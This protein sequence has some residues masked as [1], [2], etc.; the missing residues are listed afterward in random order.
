MLLALLKPRRTSP[1]GLNTLFDLLERQRRAKDSLS[2]PLRRIPGGLGQVRKD[3]TLR[4]LLHRLRK[5]HPVGSELPVVSVYTLIMS[6]ATIFKATY[7][8]VPVY[9]MPC[10]SVPVMR[11]RVDNWVNATQILKV[12]GFDKP[13]RTRV[14]EREVQKAIH[15]KIQGGYGKY[16]GTWIP[17][18]RGVALAQQ[19]G[20]IALLQPIFDFQPTGDSPPLAPKHLTAP[21]SRPKRK[22]DTPLDG[23]IPRP[24]QKRTTHGDPA[25]S[26]SDIPIM[27][28][29][30]RAGRM[31][32]S[33]DHSLSP[34]PSDHSST[35][36]TPSPLDGHYTDYD[37]HGNAVSAER[38]RPGYTD[39]NGNHQ[40][41]QSAGGPVRYARLILDYFVSESSH[42]PSFLLAPP[43]DFDPNVVIDDDGHTALH[44]A[45]AMGRIRIVKLLLTAGADIFRANAMGQ[46]ALMRSVMFTNN[47][48][49]RKFPELFELLHRSTI[50]IDR[51]D[52]TVFHY[53]V[54][55]ALQKGK[56]HAARYYAEAI[57]NRLSSYPREVADILNF[58][59]LDGET[60]LTMA[61]RAR[62]K[63]LVKILVD[64][65][66]NLQLANR[67]GKTAED[68]ILED[69]R[70]R[71]A[72][73]G[74]GGVAPGFPGLNGYN[75]TLHS[76][77]AAQRAANQAIPQS[78]EL[79]GSLANSFD[80]EL[81]EK[82]RDL[83]QAQSLLTNINHQVAESQAEINQLKSEASGLDDAKRLEASLS[84]EL[85]N[86]MGKRFRLGWERYV[87]QEEGRQ[88]DSQIGT[89]QDA[90]LDAIASV[91][92]SPDQI[93]QDC[94]AL[95]QEIATLQDS[96]RKMFADYVKL[97]AEAGTGNKMAD[98]RKLIAMG[99]GVNVN[100]VND[101][102]GS[103]A[104]ALDSQIAAPAQ[105]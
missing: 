28:N 83:N 45:C 7:S 9:E 95:R 31:P 32:G 33:D 51:H 18:E 98:Y 23:S 44:W 56:T 21:P 77:E 2:I 89:A 94:A 74:P 73:V 19:Y 10:K 42:I 50:N 101:V 49:L 29:L 8:N 100:Q 63:R 71:S 75:P 82:D 78:A 87:L 34:S 62:S 85:Q 81:D 11:R 70:F 58:Q 86:K 105:A 24:R 3:C 35:S 6:N 91:P 90:D 72:S 79:L 60:A 47:Y 88:K 40:G 55:I 103:L 65:G 46:T 5:L 68:Y 66:G 97:T 30:P 80:A 104:D 12:A 53:V 22:A 96:R 14:L 54:D 37:M 38:R 39:H 64:H 27:P 59:D 26:D 52:R 25:D 16:Q 17:M 4:H 67:D 76:S 15:E 48:D 13:Q 41:H 57:L 20:V 84:D 92:D 102:L 99:C 61:A 36:Q 69:E 1:T 93:A 43:A